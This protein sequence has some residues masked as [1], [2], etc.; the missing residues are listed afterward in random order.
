MPGAHRDGD[1]RF[2]GAKTIVI[3]QNKVVV[4]N[5]LWAVEGDIDD[6]CGEGSLSAIYGPPKIKIGEK[7]IICGVGDTASLDRA[8]GGCEV[9]HPAGSTDPKGHSFDVLVYGG[10]AGGGKFG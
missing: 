8:G 5:L 3:G 9:I 6:H 1:D 10:Q 2:C 7:Y 4:N